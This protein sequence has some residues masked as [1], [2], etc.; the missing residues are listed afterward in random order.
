MYRSPRRRVRKVRHK[1]VE[2]KIVPEVRGMVEGNGR[3]QVLAQ[4]GP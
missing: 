3:D 2:K 1:T 4:Y